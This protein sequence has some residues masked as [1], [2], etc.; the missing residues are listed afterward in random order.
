MSRRGLLQNVFAVAFPPE[1]EV[2]A[3]VFYH[4]GTQTQVADLL[5]VDERTV[6]RRWQAAC[7]RLNQ[8]VGD[9]LP[10]P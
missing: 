2:I 4:G 8:S 6:R 9:R 3:L 7:L 10:R 5:Q 1:R